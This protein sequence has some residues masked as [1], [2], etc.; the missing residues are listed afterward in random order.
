MWGFVS[1]ELAAVTDTVI[2]SCKS[3]LYSPDV[4][5]LFEAYYPCLLM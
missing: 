2:A 4:I 1:F 5:V 3:N